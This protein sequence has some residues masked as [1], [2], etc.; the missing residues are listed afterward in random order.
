MSFTVLE[1]KHFFVS[2][3]DEVRGHYDEITYSFRCLMMETGKTLEKNLR[4]T[5][6]A[7]QSDY[8]EHCLQNCATLQAQAE[9]D[10]QFYTLKILKQRD[11]N[12]KFV[13]DLYDFIHGAVWQWEVHTTGI[14]RAEDFLDCQL[15]KHRAAVQTQLETKINVR[16]KTALD[17]LRYSSNP[18]TNTAQVHACE[19]VLAD[20]EKLLQEA[21]K[22]MCQTINGTKMLCDILARV[23]CS[24]WG[25]RPRHPSNL[26][27][28]AKV[29]NLAAASSLVVH[30]DT[31]ELH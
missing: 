28:H 14:A 27:F 1:L 17:V 23:R 21:W 15:Q 2:D 16:L 29:K 3:V 10:F 26:A 8:V 31:V 20:L 11:L 24:L 7:V 22:K 9:N 5:Q 30:E 13:D 6:K 25:T 19:V 12:M 18:S 4:L